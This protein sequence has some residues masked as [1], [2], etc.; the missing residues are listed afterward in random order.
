LMSMNVGYFSIPY[1]AGT[2]FLDLDWILKHQEAERE[3][4]FIH[5]SF[6]K[7]L[8]MKIDGKQQLAVIFK[9]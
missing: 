8:V 9:N 2:D 7:P 5:Y 4:F 1:S 3:E 6:D